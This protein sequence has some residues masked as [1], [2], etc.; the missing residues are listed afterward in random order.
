MHLLCALLVIICSLSYSP[1][2]T[3]KEKFDRKKQIQ[4]YF[5]NKNDTA[6]KKYRILLYYC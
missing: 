3:S 6:S 5:Y 2:S 1:L 4:L